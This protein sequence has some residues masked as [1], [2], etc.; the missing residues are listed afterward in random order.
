MERVKARRILVLE[1]EFMVGTAIAD[2]LED[3]GYDVA[4]PVRTLLEAKRI[5]AV[6]GVEGAVLDVNLGAENSLALA[7]DI[8]R[9]GLPVLFVT[10]YSEDVLQGPLAQLPRLQKPFGEQQLLTSVAALFAAPSP[11]AAL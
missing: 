5:I 4:G 3:A 8:V 9:R 2:V 11:E 1:D 10:A 7:Q 6:E